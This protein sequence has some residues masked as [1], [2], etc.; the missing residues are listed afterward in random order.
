VKSRQLRRHGRGARRMAD[1][2]EAA[3][4][5]EGQRGPEVGVAVL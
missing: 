2:H 5:V 1:V 3:G 4:R